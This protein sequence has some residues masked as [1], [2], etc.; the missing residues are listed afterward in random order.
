MRNT[1]AKRL[2]KMVATSGAP[3]EDNYEAIRTNNQFDLRTI[4]LVEC[5]KA[6]YREMKKGFKRNA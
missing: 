3:A 5:Q 2:R 4:V 6:L 1:Q